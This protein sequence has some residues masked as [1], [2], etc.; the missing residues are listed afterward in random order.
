MGQLR[1]VWGGSVAD[2]NNCKCFAYSESECDCSAD[3]TDERVYQL[4]TELDEAQQ[5]INSVRK[6]LASTIPEHGVKEALIQ[7]RQYKKEKAV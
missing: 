2:G 5:L 3:W 6:V 4:Q 1:P 7:L